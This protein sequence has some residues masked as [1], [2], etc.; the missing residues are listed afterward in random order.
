MVFAYHTVTVAPP[1][2]LAAPSSRYG[3]LS[4]T[5]CQLPS[6]YAGLVGPNHG[7][8]NLDSKEGSVRKREVLV[9]RSHRSRPFANRG[10][11]TLH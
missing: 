11:N 5:V 2:A 4:R 9:D 10:G 8:M 3:R 7:K 1:H 6:Q